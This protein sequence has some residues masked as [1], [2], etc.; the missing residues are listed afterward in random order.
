VRAAF[1]HRLSGLGRIRQ[2]GGIYVDHHLIALP[3]GS[4]IELVM[5]RGLGQQG[6]RVRLLLRPGRGLRRRVGGRYGGLAGAAP[7]VERFAGGIQGPQE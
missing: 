1:Q 6:Q 3:S 2:D 7:L 5:Q 4:G